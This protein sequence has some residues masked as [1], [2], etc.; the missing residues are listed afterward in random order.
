MCTDEPALQ[1]GSRQNH[2]RKE[3][4][5]E[6]C[7]PFYPDSYWQTSP[8]LMRLHVP[9][10]TAGVQIPCVGILT[11]FGSGGGARGGRR[12]VVMALEKCH[13]L[14]SLL[15]L[16]GDLEVPC[17]SGKVKCSAVWRGGSR[18]LRGRQVMNGRDAEKPW[19]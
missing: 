4:R 12:S 16:R 8:K 10:K 13:A 9:G 6:S 17:G 1:D 5:G 3:K 11:S 14:G 15:R 7:G 2:H 18:R 19:D